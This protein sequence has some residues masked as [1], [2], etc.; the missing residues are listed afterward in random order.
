MS[1][2][3]I[4]IAVLLALT[5]PGFAAGH[6]SC[7]QVHNATGSN[8]KWLFSSNHKTKAGD[9]DFVAP[10]E[11]HPIRAAP[12][13]QHARAGTYLGLGADRVFNF[14]SLSDSAGSGLSETSYPK[15]RFRRFSLRC[16]KCLGSVRWTNSYSKDPGRLDG[17]KSRGHFHVLES[18]SAF[19][20]I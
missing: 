15:N 18:H 3:I 20:W 1:R 19:G 14:A 4:C 13:M 2:S 7:R 9:W 16:L 5:S 11:L 12:I 10:N 8:Q 6:R 17:K